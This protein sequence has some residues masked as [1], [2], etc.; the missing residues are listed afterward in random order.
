[1]YV[2][3]EIVEASGAGAAT[4][5]AAGSMNALGAD[6]ALESA[7]DTDDAATNGAVRRRTGDSL[8]MEVT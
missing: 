1:M 7:G 8:P 5:S 3:S 6:G 2:D 4:T